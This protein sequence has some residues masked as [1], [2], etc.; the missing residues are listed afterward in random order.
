MT[1]TILIALVGCAIIY[2]LWNIATLKSRT[3]KLMDT[4][5]SIQKNITERM[6]TVVQRDIKTLHSFM[7]AHVVDVIILLAIFV[8]L[9]IERY[10]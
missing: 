5:I 2:H 4:P 7:K 10:V 8:T 3:D 1:L 6:S 9:L